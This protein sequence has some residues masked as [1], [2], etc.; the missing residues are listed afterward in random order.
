MNLASALYHGGKEVNGAH[1]FIW[2]RMKFKLTGHPDHNS[3]NGSTLRE[4]LLY[5]KEHA[6]VLQ[7]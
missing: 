5:E 6:D 3:G 2:H 4:V 7:L 1:V